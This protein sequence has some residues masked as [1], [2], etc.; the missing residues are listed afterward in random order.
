MSKTI[1]VVE[2]TDNHGEFQPCAGSVF[3]GRE[4]AAENCD[5]KAKQAKHDGVRKRYRPMQYVRREVRS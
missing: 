5:M 1:W 3:Y 2:E 4:A